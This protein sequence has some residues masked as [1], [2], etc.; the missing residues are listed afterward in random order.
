MGLPLK[1]RRI[2]ITREEKQAKEFT[3]KVL[4]S[5]GISV[6][7]PLLKISCKCD[8]AIR[9]LSQNRELFRWL[10]FTSANGVHCFFQLLKESDINHNFLA[11]SKF[12]AVGHKTAHALEGYGCHAE[13]IPSTYTAEAITNEFFAEYAQIEEPVLIIRGNRSRSILPLW[14][15]EQGIRFETVEVYET[16]VRFSENDKLN[17]VLKQQNLDAIT[18]TSPSSVDAFMEMKEKQ[19]V[20]F[21][22]IVCIGTTTEVRAS[23]WGLTNL[24]V[25]EEF[26]IDGMMILMEEYF[27]Q[28]G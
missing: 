19:Y 4:Q 6:E 12:A 3:Y 10:F 26:T 18:F 17:A 16:S 7:V 13:F 25:P 28:K 21:P 5:G 14:L 22:P 24:L 9:Q 20:H 27:E 8:E 23:E 1:D 2:L 11:E 15:K